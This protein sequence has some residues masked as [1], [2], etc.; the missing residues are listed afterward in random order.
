MEEVTVLLG[1]VKAAEFDELVIAVIGESRIEGHLVTFGDQCRVEVVER[2]P[3]LE[4]SFLHF[5]VYFF[6]QRA[7]GVFQEFGGLLQRILLAVDLHGHF[8]GNGP[9][10][11][12]HHGQ[13]SLQGNI[14]LPKQFNVFFDRAQVGKI[15]LLIQGSGEGAA[16]QLAVEQVGI[17]LYMG[18]DLHHEKV[19][20]LLQ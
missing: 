15:F 1:V 14:G 6:P 19:E 7:V 20:G 8:G 13:F 9:E 18:L 16:H 17:G 3:V 4:P 12:A 11:L 5:T 2:P 10:L